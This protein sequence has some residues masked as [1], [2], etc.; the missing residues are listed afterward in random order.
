MAEMRRRPPRSRSGGAGPRPGGRDRRAPRA[1]AD[2]HPQAP[3]Q[4]GDEEGNRGRTDDRLERREH[5]QCATDP[6]DGDDDLVADRATDGQ[7]RRDPA[8]RRPRAALLGVGVAVTD[9][10]R[11]TYVA[12]SAP[13]SGAETS[14]TT[15]LNGSV[16]VMRTKNGLGNTAVGMPRTS[17]VSTVPPIA[18]SQKRRSS[19]ARR[20]KS[21]SYVTWGTPSGGCRGDRADHA[22]WSGASAPPAPHPAMNDQQ[23][24]SRAGHAYE[25][26]RPRLRH[27]RGRRPGRGERPHP[28]A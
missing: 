5:V 27:D 25:G 11:E 13:M 26:H 6:E 23:G 18:A 22:S 12:S 3:G 2:P 8:H 20:R 17:R 19:V 28:R 16:G 9:G 1:A 7:E 14:Q 24:V 4:R 15:T 21:R 10:P